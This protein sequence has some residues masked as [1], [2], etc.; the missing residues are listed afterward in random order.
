M[1]LVVTGGERPLKVS[2]SV[3]RRR[4]KS[5]E[6]VSSAEEALLAIQRERPSL[7]I[8]GRE[9][10]DMSGPEFC[11]VVRE[12]SLTRSTSLLR[13]AD[14]D[15]KAEAELCLAAGCNDILYRPYLLGELDGKIQKLSVV[16]VRKEIRTLVRMQVV[17]EADGRVILGNSLNVSAS[18]ILVQSEHHF[19]HQSLLRLHFYLQNDPLPILTDSLLVR[20][21]FNGGEPR[22]GLQYLNLPGPEQARLEAFVRRLRA[23]DLA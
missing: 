17:V 16:P 2:E 6:V 5:V 4:E 1:I 3:L 22:Y 21:E 11:R 14:S 19:A 15:E 12:N 20:A 18:G 13:I 9:M 7:V 23:R 8:F 10:P